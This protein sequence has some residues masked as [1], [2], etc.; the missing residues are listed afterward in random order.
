MVTTL[1]VPPYPADGQL[2][3]CVACGVLATVV[4]PDSGPDEAYEAAAIASGHAL[5][6]RGHDVYVASRHTRFV[7]RA[8]RS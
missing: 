6:E 5:A 4:G 3:V 8:A 2:V 7:L 1:E